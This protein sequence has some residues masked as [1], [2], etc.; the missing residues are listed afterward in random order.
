M[1]RCKNFNSCLYFSGKTESIRG[2]DLSD[3]ESIAISSVA[4]EVETQFGDDEDLE[5]D[6]LQEKISE[7]II[8]SLDK[9]Y[10]FFE[11]YKPLVFKLVL[12]PWAF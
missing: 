2:S 6:L 10:F 5:E 12:K 3:L 4:G 8:D 7:N 11:I 1:R 9:R